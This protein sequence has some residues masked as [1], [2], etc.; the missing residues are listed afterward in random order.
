MTSLSARALVGERGGKI[1]RFRKWAFSR[2]L[3]TSLLADSWVRDCSLRFVC[4][5][6]R[7]GSVHVVS[8]HSVTLSTKPIPS[9]TS[10]AGTFAQAFD[11]CHSGWRVF[12]PDASDAHLALRYTE[13]HNLDVQFGIRLIKSHD[14]IVRIESNHFKMNGRDVNFTSIDSNSNHRVVKSACGYVDFTTGL[15]ILLAAM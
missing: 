15:W 3:F 12:R 10:L 9:V 6:Q 4:F 2:E 14:P 1:V 5:A 7:N 13:V 8:S 11:A